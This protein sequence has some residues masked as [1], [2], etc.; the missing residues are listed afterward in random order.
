MQS[1]CLA[2]KTDAFALKT[3][4]LSI[5]YIHLANYRG[6]GVWH[7]SPPPGP[8][9]AHS[10]HE[11]AATHLLEPFLS[12]S[13]QTAGSHLDSGNEGFS[14]KKKVTQS[15]YLIKDYSYFEKVSV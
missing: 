13:A 9:R 4:D 15:I 7:L 1:Q 12:R 11:N 2:P 8:A 6:D 10:T 3:D 5:Y 14:P